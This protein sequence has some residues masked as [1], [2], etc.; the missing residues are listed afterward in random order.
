MP[1]SFSLKI[2]VGIFHRDPSRS[3]LRARLGGHSPP[4]YTKFLLDF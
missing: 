3:L 2:Y 1:V 4:A